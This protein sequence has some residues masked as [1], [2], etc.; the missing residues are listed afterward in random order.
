MKNSLLT[1][2]FLAATISLFA[3]EKGLTPLAGPNSAQSG[4][5]YAVVV[6]I[7]DYQ[8]TRIPDL[9]FADKDAEAFANFLRSPAGGALDVDHLKVLLNAE[10]TMAQFAAALDWL[11]EV[12]KEG[13][14]AIIYFSGHGDVEKKSLT[15]PGFLLCWDAPARVYMG[16]GAFALPML[17]EVI[18]TLSIQNKAKVVVIT[19][20]CRSGTLAGQ[21]VGGSQATAANLAKQYANEIKILSCQPNE[22]SIEGEQWGGGRG[23]FSY[24]LV[25]ALYGL[26]DGNSD[27]SVTLQEVGRYL[28]DHVT[29]EV[30]P[31]SQ[32]PMV[33]GNR[34]ERMASVNVGMLA[35][36]RNGKTSQMAM[37][38][39]IESRGI[40][41]EVLAS[42]DTTTREL[43]KLF[44]KVLKDK[45]FLEPADNCADAYFER[46][47]AEPKLIRLYSTMRRNYAAALQDDA[48][49]VL[50][51]MLKSGLTS[52]ILSGEKAA[53]IYRHYPAYLERAAELLGSEHYM[54]AD[55]KA[56][57]HYFESALKTEKQ[58]KK[59]Q[60]FQALEW[61]SNMAHAHAALIKLYSAEQVDSA[62]YHAARAMEIAP[63]WVQPY[64]NL[65]S[66]FQDIKQADKAEEQLNLAGQVDSNSILVWYAKAKFYGGQKK[67]SEAEHWYL[68]AIEGSG[69]EIC[70]PCAHLNLGRV[71]HRKRRYQEAEQ[72][73]KKA[74]Q[75][76]STVAISYYNLGCLCDQMGRFAE[77]EELFKKAIQLDSTDAP[78]YNNLGYVY[79]ETHRYD[80]AEQYYKKALQ[81]DS[82]T[83]LFYNNLGV[84]YNITGRYSEAE[85]QLKKALQIDST[86]SLTYNNLGIGYKNTH[87]YVEAEQ[88][89]KKAIQ[90]DST[91]AS[92][93][94]NLG[95]VYSISRRYVE[96]E[97][98]FKKVIQLGSIES[99]SYF[100]LARLQ[101]LQNR[102][103]AAFAYLEK[104][105]KFGYNKYDGLQEDSDL[106]PLREQK[107]RWASLMHQYFLDQVN[108]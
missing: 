60:Y 8:D 104:A 74:I 108:K 79:K 30:A 28:E 13:D 103:D 102:S 72:A 45:V 10:A 56:R 51:T 105:L 5:T 53:Y 58:Q 85:Q 23:A 4:S 73:Y 77:A 82:T 21:S 101:C 36:L 62:E 33:L 94:Y 31:V 80:E 63:S 52:E 54:F 95:I 107:E 11:W 50:N 7:S 91:D 43:Y 27:L 89:Y 61:Q 68:K 47:T 88:Q 22:Y 18:S 83:S 48:Q 97:Q 44:K 1:I 99:G 69:D 42:V 96:S 14:Q 98:Q 64:I 26:A 78:F 84:V 57:R 34:T 9:R 2:I 46:L 71:Y 3:Q 38:S 49:Q 81:L 76:D 92:F 20:A 100:N 29:E 65:S 25:D 93:Y 75:L 67:Y 40:E 39:A 19:D 59:Q 41:E 32:V 106:A 87:R 6:G 86:F 17:Q 35:D 12:S 24:N 15:Q 55:L 70:F 37:L 16:G 90:L 66:F